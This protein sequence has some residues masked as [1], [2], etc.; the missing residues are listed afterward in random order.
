[1]PLQANRQATSIRNEKYDGE[2]QDFQT[3]EFFCQRSENDRTEKLPDI[4]AKNDHAD[5]GGVSF[6]RKQGWSM[7]NAMHRTV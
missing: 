7:A 4:M 2:E 5:F 1:M 3:A 6:I